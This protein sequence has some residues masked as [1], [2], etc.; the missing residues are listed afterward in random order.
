V[1]IDSDR[2]GR[3]VVRFGRSARADEIFQ[4]VVDGIRK[5]VSVGYR[6]HAAKLV[7]TRDDDLDVYRITD[8]EPHEI[9]IVSVPADT[10]V[11]VGR[12][13]ENPRVA[14]PEAA[15]ETTRNLTEAHEMP[16]P[17]EATQNP[18]AA[19]DA[20]AAERDRA[21]SIA[22][23]GEKFGDSALAAR[24]ISDG[25]SVEDF[26]RSLLDAVNTRASKPL[27]EQMRDAEIGMTD[28]E[29]QRFSFV[30]L[31]RAATDPAD[32]SAQKE[33]AF[34]LDVC[35]AAAEKSTKAVRGMVVPVD[36][37]TRA[38]SPMN[39]GTSGTNTGDTGGSIVATVLQA[40]SFIELLRN[41]S[42]LMRR[43]RVLGGL[44][45]NID[46]PKQTGGATA[47]W[48]GE[49]G[50][51]PATSITLGQ[52]GLSPKTLAAYSEVTR[53]LLMQASPDAELLL[54]YD[55]ATSIGLASDLAGFYGTGTGNEPR[56]IVN[57]A[58]INAVDFGTDGVGAGTGQLPTYAEL[59]QM[60]TEIA[61]D[62]ADVDSM[63][64]VLNARMR[65]HLKTTE[66]FAG[67]SGATI[68][69]PGNTVNGYAA[70][71]T[72]QIQN[73]DV[74]FGNFADLIVGMWGGLDILV[75]P[76]TNSAKGRIRIVTFQDF[77][78]QLRRVESFCLGR[79][80][81]A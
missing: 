60:E 2:K 63:A 1:R 61:A 43:A 6:V 74:I 12:E 5:L 41:K 27:A 47:G 79:D 8:W 40:G 59:V 64:Y 66:K 7:E 25:T 50:D 37:L 16:A 42:V 55:L 78:Y 20:A 21:R 39:T 81:T 71:V 22:E 73:G 36:V 76:Y 34:E 54:R 57:Y 80:S 48:I 11:G 14:A 4:D 13:M 77:D 33:A 17:A 44:V 51:A 62:N 15:A 52:I 68:W 69:E 18:A 75:D 10:T 70:D 32:K 53:R 72:N 9:S 30:R 45:G 49:D 56:G 23:M 26:Q 31:M 65:G 24:A 35:R 67:T 46:I 3:A 38:W 19:P 29:T 58:G 28:K